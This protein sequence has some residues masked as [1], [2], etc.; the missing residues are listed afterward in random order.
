M[1]TFT[2][3][4]SYGR[5]GNQLFQ[6]AALKATAM[7]HNYVCKVPNFYNKTFHGQSCQLTYLNIEADVL[8]EKDL[9]SIKANIVEP[10]NS[11]PGQFYPN[12][13]SKVEP[14]SNLFGFF[15]NT[16]YFCDFEQQIKK[17]LTPKI[18]ILQREER[19]FKK[20]T[21][22][23]K[24]VSLHIRTGDMIDGSNPI[25]KPYYGNGPFDS[26]CAVGEYITKALDMFPVDYKIVV[27]VGG[28]RTGDDKSDILWAKKHFSDGKFIVS[29]TNN[30]LMDFMRIMLCEHNIIS[31]AS[32]FSWW[33]AYL[34]PNSSKLVVCPKNYL[35]ETKYEGTQEGFYPTNWKQI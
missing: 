35:L 15:Q 21:N 17:E 10:P 3:L 6:Y 7:K 33:A 30:P 9:A 4:G 34:N 23:S 28:S 2:E 5:F 1:L 19:R 12:L 29:D 13:L 18:E 16:K 14:N 11:T 22:N 25:Y 32:T 27:F 31:F 8:T 24:L 26:S 20:E